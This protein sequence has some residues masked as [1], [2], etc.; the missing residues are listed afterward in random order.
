MYTSWN[1]PPRRMAVE[2][3]RL[4]KLWIGTVMSWISLCFYI[5]YSI[6]AQRISW[7]PTYPVPAGTFESMIL[8]FPRWNMLV[9]WRVSIEPSVMHRTMQEHLQGRSVPSLQSMMHR[10]NRWI[11]KPWWPGVAGRLYGF[12]KGIAWFKTKVAVLPISIIYY[13]WWKKSCTAGFMLK[14]NWCRNSSISNST[15]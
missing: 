4:Q 13:C 3:W 2:K 15:Q 7:P 8:L 14:I 10:T 11:A 12:E 9:P 6:Y 5:N 1:T